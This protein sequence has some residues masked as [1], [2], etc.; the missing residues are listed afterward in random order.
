MSF[1]INNCVSVAFV[2]LF[3]RSPFLVLY[4]AISRCWHGSAQFLHWLRVSRQKNN[5]DELK[6]LKHRCLPLRKI[7]L[8][9]PEAWKLVALQ[10]LIKKQISF[11]SNR[12]RAEGEEKREEEKGV[13]TCII[14]LVNGTG[15]SASLLSAMVGI[16]PETQNGSVNVSSIVAFGTDLHSLSLGHWISFPHLL[17]ENNLS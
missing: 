14:K 10:G 16:N 13:A 4:Y 6:V 7:V 9:F 17:N 1:W 5:L 3:L 2:M 11:I 15:I 12:R 8:A